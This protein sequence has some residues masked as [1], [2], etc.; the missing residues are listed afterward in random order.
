M[1]I[2]WHDI[3]VMTQTV[4]GEAR[5]EPHLGKVAVASAILNRAKRKHRGCSSVVEVCKRPRQF[6]CWNPEDP[7]ASQ[8]AQQMPN[9]PSMPECLAAVAQAIINMRAGQDITNG[10]LH[11]YASRIAAPKWAVGKTPCYEVGGHLFFND[12]DP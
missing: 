6:S 9:D 10:A 7:N 4:R 3:E 1:R 8:C 12:I 11:Y 5:G 2:T